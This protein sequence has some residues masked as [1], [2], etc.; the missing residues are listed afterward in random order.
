[1]IFS[2]IEKNRI[3]IVRIKS[4]VFELESSITRVIPCGHELITF[5][6]S[7]AQFEKCEFTIVNDHFENK[8]NAVI[9]LYRQTLFT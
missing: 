9:G 2:G 8:H 1:M 7:V 3:F 6:Y 5:S 4:Q